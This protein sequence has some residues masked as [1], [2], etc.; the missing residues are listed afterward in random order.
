M[1]DDQKTNVTAGV[2]TF[3]ACVALCP[4]GS[5]CQLV[6]YDYVAKTCTIRR[7]APVDVSRCPPAKRWVIKPNNSS[8]SWGVRDAH[9]RVELARSVA[10]HNG[11][12]IQ[13]KNTINR[14]AGS[15]FIEEKQYQA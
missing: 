7:G 9:N 8:A 13:V 1:S 11:D 10:R 14:L 2:N 12:R 15:R 4:E 6:T 3:A 5:D